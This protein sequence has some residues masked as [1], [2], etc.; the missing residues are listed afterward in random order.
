MKLTPL[1][2]LDTSFI[3]E[4]YETV[5]KTDVPVTVTK[6]EDVSATLSAGFISGGASTTETKEFPL[7]SHRMFERVRKE[8]EKLPSVDLAT[9]EYNQLPEYFWTQ[10][11]FGASAS[12]TTRGNEVLHRESYFR[13]YSDL[14]EHKR[15]LVLVTNDVYLATGYDQVQKHLAGSCQGFGIAV[16]G[17]F[18]FLASDMMHSPICAPLVMEKIGN[19]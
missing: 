12:Q 15:S 8:L 18:K 13:L 4:V 11:V 6:T 3:V 1:V 19:V 2:Y 5:T 10:G 14:K 17:L 9:T 16:K 7:N